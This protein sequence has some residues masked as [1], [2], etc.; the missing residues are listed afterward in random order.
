M[1]GRFWIIEAAGRSM[2]TGLFLSAVFYATSANAEPTVIHDRGHTRPITD[3]VFLPN[4]ALPPIT[5][6][7][8]VPDPN[9]LMFQVFP[10]QSAGLTPGKVSRRAVKLPQLPAP[11]FLI[12]TDPRSRRWLLQYRDRLQELQAVGLVVEAGSLQKFRALEEI[13]LDLSLTPA[14]ALVLAKQLGLQHYPALISRTLI[15]Q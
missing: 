2:A 11:L 5:N 15:E 9:A 7:P 6:P 4:T 14:P 10:V 1:N 12:G 13:A 8:R 3:Y